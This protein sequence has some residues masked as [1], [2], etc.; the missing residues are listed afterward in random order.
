MPRIYSLFSDYSKK[1]ANWNAHFQVF[2]FLS[3]VFPSTQVLALA[4]FLIPG[5]PPPAI[6]SPDYEWWG[7]GLRHVFCDPSDTT[8]KPP[9]PF[10]SQC[11]FSAMRHHA[12]LYTKMFSS[13]GF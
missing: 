12:L 7:V 9:L 6:F 2:F 11:P 10:S 4:F 8:S 3:E 1:P 13:T 5:S